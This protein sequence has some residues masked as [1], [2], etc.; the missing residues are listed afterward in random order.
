MPVKTRTS[1]VAHVSDLCKTDTSEFNSLI[2]VLLELGAGH[3]RCWLIRRQSGF[4]SHLQLRQH[5]KWLLT[6]T[7]YICLSSYAFPQLHVSPWGRLVNVGQPAA[8]STQVSR[9]HTMVVTMDSTVLSSCFV[10]YSSNYYGEAAAHLI[11]EG[12]G[13]PASP[14]RRRQ[15][16]LKS[17]LQ[18]HPAQ[19]MPFEIDFI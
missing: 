7:F 2:L 10:T 6:S 13:A 4:T 16:G 15:S 3:R 9:I 14:A 8:S 18:L 19:Q 5:N 17:H 1:R 11:E 12:A